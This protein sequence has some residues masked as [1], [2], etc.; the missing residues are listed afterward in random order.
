MEALLEA[1]HA[2]MPSR[3]SCLSWV[4][5]GAWGPQV[6]G[7]GWERGRERSGSRTQDRELGGEGPLQDFGLWVTR[8]TAEGRWAGRWQ[9]AR[10]SEVTFS[11]SGSVAHPRL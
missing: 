1:L 4:Y 7:K 10:P 9:T 2:R 8:R 11:L 6:G 5:E 3:S